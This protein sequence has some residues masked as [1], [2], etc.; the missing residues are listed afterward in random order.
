MEKMIHIGKEIEKIVRKQKI[1]IKDFADKIH[2]TRK[3]V[4][5][6][7]TRQSIDIERLILISEILDYDFIHNV[8]FKEEAHKIHK[9][10][11]SFENGIFHL[12]NKITDV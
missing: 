11:V 12:E 1:S 10:V 2:C 4:Y 3:N 8:Y 7:F 9:C 5:D 6:I